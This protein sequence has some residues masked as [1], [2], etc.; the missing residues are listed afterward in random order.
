MGAGVCVAEG[1]LVFVIAGVTVRDC[2]A[3]ASVHAVNTIS[4]EVMKMSES[5][6]LIFLNILVMHDAAQRWL[7]VPGGDDP[8]TGWQGFFAAP[9]TRL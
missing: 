6:C 2:N 8:E 4:V 7:H 9:S 5:K 3:T 1:A